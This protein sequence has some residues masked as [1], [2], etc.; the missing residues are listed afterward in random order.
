MELTEERK[1]HI[2]GLSY[3]QLLSKWRFAPMGESWFQGETGKYWG[4]RLA[5]KRDADPGGAVAASKLI[6]W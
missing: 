3:E 2:D 6:G 5:E 1:A 4:D